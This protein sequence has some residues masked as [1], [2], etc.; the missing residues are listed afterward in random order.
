LASS[1]VIG[2]LPK[3]GRLVRDMDAANAKAE[4]SRRLIDV[5]MVASPQCALVLAVVYFTNSMSLSCQF[6]SK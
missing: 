4:K 5:D 1:G 6:L 2:V 3:D